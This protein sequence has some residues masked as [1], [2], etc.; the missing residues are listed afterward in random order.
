MEPVLFLNQK[1]TSRF[2]YTAF[3]MQISLIGFFTFRARFHADFFADRREN[4]ILRAYPWNDIYSG[5]Y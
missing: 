4:A 5:R 2:Q 3:I 1:Y